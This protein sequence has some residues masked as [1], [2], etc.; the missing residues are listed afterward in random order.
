MITS[1][2]APRTIELPYSWA[3]VEGTVAVRIAV[4]TDPVTLGCHEVAQGFPYF[5]ATV[6]S[7]GVGYDHVYGW[8][9]MV[10]QSF[11]PG[12][13]VD[14]HPAFASSLPFLAF[15]PLSGFFDGP[16]TDERDWDFLAHTFFCGKGGLLHEFRKEARAILG[17][18]WGLSKR[19]QR[20]EWFGPQPLA[21]QDWDSHLERLTEER[22]DWAFKA[23]FSQHPLEP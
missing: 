23:G 17:F 14:E 11:E 2:E 16:H 13:R 6:E 12:F 5:L 21:A 4:N 3:D 20:V 1:P 9:Q 10:D 7:E 15:G 8:I 19:D 18:G 22:W